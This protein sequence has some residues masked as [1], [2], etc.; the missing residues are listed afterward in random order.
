MYEKKPYVFEIFATDWRDNK[1]L[2]LSY[3]MTFVSRFYNYYQHFIYS[4]GLLHVWNKRDDALCHVLHVFLYF[5][6]HS[7]EA[8]FPFLRHGYNLIEYR[9]YYGT[10]PVYDDVL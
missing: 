9:P 10:V 1:C 6:F 5:P 4:F 8:Y 7:H 2:K 3:I